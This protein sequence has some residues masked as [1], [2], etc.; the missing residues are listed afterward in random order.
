MTKNTSASWKF[1]GKRNIAIK[2][3]YRTQC[4]YPRFILL[5]KLAL[6]VLGL[7]NLEDWCNSYLNLLT[8]FDKN[9]ILVQQE[10]QLIMSLVNKRQNETKLSM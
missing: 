2:E 4:K 9:D 1:I 5:E 7:N 6:L 8:S 10:Q 3:H